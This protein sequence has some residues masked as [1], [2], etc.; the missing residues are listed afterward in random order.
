MVYLAKCDSYSAIHWYK[1]AGILLTNPLAMVESSRLAMLGV[2]FQ[3][4]EVR[5]PDPNCRQPALLHF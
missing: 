1:N 4:A 3:N 2:G 5:E